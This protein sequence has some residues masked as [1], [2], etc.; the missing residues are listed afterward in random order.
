M[1]MVPL[2]TTNL[3]DMSRNSVGRSMIEKAEGKTK[4]P[5]RMGLENSDSFSLVMIRT[6]VVLQ[7]FQQKISVK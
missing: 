5:E 1:G 2:L 3:S 7:I 4:N 6:K